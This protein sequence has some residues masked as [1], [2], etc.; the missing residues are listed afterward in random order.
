M[1]EDEEAMEC[2]V[3]ME[4]GASTAM[5]P[6]GH[7]FCCRP[8]CGSHSV[9]VCPSCRAPVESRTVL[10]GAHVTSQYPQLA[11]LLDAL[12]RSAASQP[13]APVPNAECVGEERGGACVGGKGGGGGP[14]MPEIG[15]E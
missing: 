2:S 12:A 7:C 10:F 13:A 15:P 11:T 1:L 14:E 9:D 5:V 4:A 6:C 3:C 8:T